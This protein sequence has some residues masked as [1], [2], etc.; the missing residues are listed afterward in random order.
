MASEP[1]RVVVPLLSPIMHGDEV[2]TELELTEPELGDMMKL[3]EAAGDMSQT[4]YTICAC[5][6]LPPSVIKQ[7]K[8]RDVKTIGEAAAR[9]L[10]EASPATGGKQRR[11]SPISSIGRLVS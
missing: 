9:M 11:G 10:G 2:L 4:L 7:L 6:K 1:I 5:A 3:D 8:L